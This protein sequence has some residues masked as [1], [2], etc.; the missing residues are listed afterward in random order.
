MGLCYT[1]VICVIG[2]RFPKLKHSWNPFGTLTSLAY[3]LPQLQVDIIIEDIL[4]V[5][6]ILYSQNSRRILQEKETV[7]TNVTSSLYLT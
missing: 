7:Y 3:F 5:H 6:C 4:S 1:D 2:Q